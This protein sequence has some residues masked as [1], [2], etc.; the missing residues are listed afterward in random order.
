MH[1]TNS[2][3]LVLTSSLLSPISVA[4]SPNPASYVSGQTLTFTATV[5][6]TSNSQNIPTGTVTWSDGNVG[7]VFGT[8]PVH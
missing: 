2:G 8:L 7:G 6:D 3:T 1:T 4:V 5:T